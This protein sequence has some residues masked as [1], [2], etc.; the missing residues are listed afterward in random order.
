[1]RKFLLL[2]LLVFPVL[3]QADEIVSG[4][5]LSTP[6]SCQVIWSQRELPCEVSLP[7]DSISYRI[8]MSSFKSILPVICTFTQVSQ[9]SY[10]ARLGSFDSGH[11]TIELQGTDRYPSGPVGTFICTVRTPE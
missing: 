7:E 9:G 10:D 5:L 1:M 2:T 4:F 11:F 6:D 8:D 3:A